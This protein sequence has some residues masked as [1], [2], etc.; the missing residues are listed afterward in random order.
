MNSVALLAGSNLG[1][2]SGNLA[3][4]LDMIK[5][6]STLL[7]VSPV[8][9]TAAWGQNNQPDF[10]NQAWLIQTMLKPHDLL[11]HILSIEK[12][13]GRVRNEKWS[14]GSSTLIFFF[15]TIR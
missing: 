12:K 14:Q 7:A 9:M 8:Y 15:M 2:R 11:H 6:E 1:D 5:S 3:L 4:A 10:Y 13:M